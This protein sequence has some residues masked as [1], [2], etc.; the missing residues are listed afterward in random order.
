M[1]WSSDQLPW[2]NFKY[3]NPP[4]PKGSLEP[5]NWMKGP[6]I[7]AGGGGVG[8]P[9]GPP[10][11]ISGEI[12]NLSGTYAAT[13][14]YGK[15]LKPFYPNRTTIPYNYNPPPVMPGLTAVMQALRLKG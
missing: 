4:K 10:I 8:N 2:N 11:L 6:P 15:G 7:L 5:L 3:P 12:R 1:Q 13:V 14:L 9:S